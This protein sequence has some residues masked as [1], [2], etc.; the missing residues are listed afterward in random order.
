MLWAGKS[1]I[2]YTDHVEG[3]AFFFPCVVDQAVELIAITKSH[4]VFVESGMT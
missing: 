1:N 2:R 4:Q 3:V